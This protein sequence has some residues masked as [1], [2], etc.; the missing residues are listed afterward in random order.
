M[1]TRRTRRIRRFA[2]AA[3]T[4]ATVYAGLCLYV[5]LI[6]D[7]LTFKPDRTIHAT[8][9]DWGLDFIG[10]DIAASD[11]TQLYG[12]YLPQEGAET[13]VL[14]CHGNAGNISSYHMKETAQT[15]ARL[16]VG[17]L[18]FDYRGYGRSEGTPSEF[19]TYHDAEGAWKFL[20]GRQGIPANRIAVHGRSL[21]GAVAAYLAEQHEPRALILESTFTTFPAIGQERYPYLPVD[22]LV[23]SRYPTLRRMA[24]VR[25]PVL[26]IHSREDDFVPF[27]FGR[28][29]YEA[30]NE[31][32]AFLELH[33]DHVRGFVDNLPAYEKGLRE[34]LRED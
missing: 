30:A 15:Y 2:V 5:Y 25:C 12:W 20:T 32:K 28:A 1:A 11:G 6:Q 14:F 34:F 4:V 13:V 22:W 3:A 31:P 27:R 29:L 19:G 23:T 33:G 21:G 24:S 26:V 16:G 7:S 10:V 17:L 18:L 8:P 9:L